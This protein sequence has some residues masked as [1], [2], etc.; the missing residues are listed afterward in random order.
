MEKLYVYAYMKADENQDDSSASE[1][2]S[3]A[4]TLYSQVAASVLL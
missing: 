2:S 1:M 3:R 4:E